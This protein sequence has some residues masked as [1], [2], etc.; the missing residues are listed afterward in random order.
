M[1]WQSMYGF[2]TNNYFKGDNMNRLKKMLMKCI[3]GEENIQAI[4]DIFAHFEKYDGGLSIDIEDYDGNSIGGVRLN[5]IIFNHKTLEQGEL[6]VADWDGD[7]IWDDDNTDLIRI[8]LDGTLKTR[9]ELIQQE[10]NDLQTGNY[11]HCS[12][13]LFRDEQDLIVVERYETK[14][15]SMDK[16][17]ILHMLINNEIKEFH[18]LADNCIQLCFNG[19]IEYLICPICA[20]GEKKQWFK[21]IKNLLG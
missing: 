8:Q 17:E 18:Q 20:D 12:T 16:E 14:P 1:V 7:Y 10:W 11:I 9:N 6:S 15:Y 13:E 3:T 2:H 19:D 5:G 4:E 21:E